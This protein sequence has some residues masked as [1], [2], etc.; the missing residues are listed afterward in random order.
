MK[1]STQDYR[2]ARKSYAQ[3]KTTNAPQKKK[4]KTTSRKRLTQFEV[5]EL[6]LKDNIHR[7]TELF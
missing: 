6:L 2:Q 1:K 3:K 7:D 5:T 4:Q